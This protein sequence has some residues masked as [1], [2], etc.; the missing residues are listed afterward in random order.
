MTDVMDDDDEF[1]EYDQETLDAVFDVMM[2]AE[3]MGPDQAMSF[4]QCLLTS[5]AATLA[6][7]CAYD[8]DTLDDIADAVIECL[9]EPGSESETET[10]EPQYLAEDEP[11]FSPEVVAG[12]DNADFFIEGNDTCH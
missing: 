5:A 11:K 9:S 2:T 10:I 3:S 1:P 12:I 7:A 8:P 6:C 4:L